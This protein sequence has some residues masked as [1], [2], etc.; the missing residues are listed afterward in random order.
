MKNSVVYV[1]HF[2]FWILIGFLSYVIQGSIFF[3]NSEGVGVPER[4]FIILTIEG[5]SIIVFYLFYFTSPFF[6]KRIRRIYF[7][8]AIIIIIAIGHGF[9]AKYIGNNSTYL[10]E[11]FSIYTPILILIFFAFIFRIVN[12]WLKDRIIN[13][14]LEKG[15]ITVQLELLKSKI[16]PHFLFNSLNNIDILIDE[17][18]KIASEYLKKLSDILRYVLYETKEDETELAKEIAQIK[19]YIELQKIRTTN[20]HFVNFTITGEIKAQKIAPMIFLPFIENAFKHSKNKNIDNAIDI[21]FEI[22]EDKVKMICKNYYEENHLEIEKNEGLGI[23]TIHQRL[24]L[25]Y[26][27]NHE[28]VIDKTEHWFIVTLRINLDDSN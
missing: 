16:N 14:E 6:L 28:L 12:K 5:F 8:F 1:L 13:S 27:I 4:L 26:P 21:E 7:L 2:S 20:S 15:K 18:P 9:E 23:E 22:N 25:L 24:N 10:L 19:N 17:T 3:W 11:I